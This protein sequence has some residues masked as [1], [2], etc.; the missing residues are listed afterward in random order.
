[1][2]MY[3]VQRT[4]RIKLEPTPE[5]ANLLMQTLK[6]FTQSFNEVVAVAN[7]KNLTNGVELHKLTYNNQRV[8]TNLP[9]QLV[10][11][12]RVK[13]TEVFKSVVARRKKGKKAKC[14]RS[15]LCAI[16]YDARSYKF[17][18]VKRTVSL[19]HVQQPGQKH[20]RAIIPVFIPDFFNRYLGK[21][22]QTD[23]ADLIYRK[24]GFW[25]H[26][27]VS[28]DI[29][30]VEPTEKA[31]GVDLGI[32]R[33]AVTSNRK[34]FGGKARK[35]INNRYF[36]LRRSLQAKGTKSAK[37]HLKKLSGKLARFQRDVNHCVSKAIVLNCSPGDMI[38][39]EN[40]TDIRERVKGRRQQRRAMSNW[41]F[42]Q[43]QG[44]VEYK[45]RFA[46]IGIKYV[47]ARYTSQGCSSCGVVDK[48]SRRNQS[49]FVCKHCGY[50]LNADLNAAK[51]L[52]SRAIGASGGLPSIS[53]S[54]P[55][56]VEV[57]AAKL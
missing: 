5:Q 29:S 11:A 15:E 48:R 51:N 57:Q 39:M 26:I 13:A 2:N 52:A 38:A 45:A 21:E 56:S 50:S 22:W 12:A 37:R 24:G 42:R 1:M 41:N 28:S 16:R 27:V 25:L 8:T 35:E 10:C 4:I 43:L 18:R 32:S 6:Q 40:L 14:P 20:N 53:L 36:R 44:F 17:D 19:V 49:E 46:G 9:A 23:S 55:T 54:H 30:E 34:F 7:E 47:D 3:T 33:I 31:V